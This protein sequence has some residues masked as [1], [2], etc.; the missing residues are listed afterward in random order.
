MIRNRK[1]SR[2]RHAGQTG[3]S[4]SIAIGFNSGTSDRA[5][6]GKLPGFCIFRNS[7]DAS[8]M[9]PVDFGMM[10]DLIESNTRRDPEALRQFVAAL[11]SLKIA[12][13]PEK[14]VTLQ[15]VTAAIMAAKPMQM[16]APDGIF[17]QSVEF[18]IPYSANR[19]D[20]GWNI[21]T[22]YDDQYT[23]FKVEGCRGEFCCGDGETAS[24][25]Q[26][27]GSR[28]QIACNP[29]GRA[30]VT[31][32][33]FC[34]YSMPQPTG[35]QDKNG[36]DY[37]AT[38][39]NAVGRLTVII[40]RRKENGAPDVL[41][42]NTDARF[43]FKTRS[44]TNQIKLSTT[45][46]A[47]CERLGGK[48]DRVFGTLLFQRR[49][50]LAPVHAGGQLTQVGRVE[51]LINEASVQ[52][53]QNQLA[54]FLLE[55]APK[56]NTLQLGSEPQDIAG[57]QAED[58]PPVDIQDAEYVEEDAVNALGPEQ[59]AETA[60]LVPQ[61]VK[62]APVKPELDTATRPPRIAQ[63][64]R[65]AD[66]CAHIAEIERIDTIEVLKAVTVGQNGGFFASFEVMERF[67]ADQPDRF[68]KAVAIY[69]KRAETR[70]AEGM[71][72]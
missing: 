63:L 1:Y 39:C 25:W 38:A 64:D 3:A 24:R 9:K 12:F 49:K 55:A 40:I 36:R 54:N 71:A 45:L 2:E 10:F 23:A 47:V 51:I 16:K 31:A 11:T 19:T 14:P 6:F 8:G 18:V 52:A 46:L 35:K 53:R 28:I 50:A 66:L 58:L 33:Q 17:P 68:D 57:E 61:E 29:V 21:R 43:E 32:D 22:I 69:L 60:D 56:P 13:D 41:G 20:D 34:P 7:E 4:H 44:E 5:G 70:L 37:T 27:D 65:L 30:G 72:R 48:I 15:T 26:P 59:T 62:P 42:R 67:A